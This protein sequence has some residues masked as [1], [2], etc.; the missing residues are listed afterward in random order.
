MVDGI[1]SID[2][3][4]SH[5]G[6]DFYK[7][8][9][10]RARGQSAGKQIKK[11]KDATDSTDSTDFFKNLIHEIRGICGVFKSFLAEFILEL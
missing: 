6:S 7:S 9:R 1:P 4:G 3:P 2:N 5:N 8:F 11:N 10:G